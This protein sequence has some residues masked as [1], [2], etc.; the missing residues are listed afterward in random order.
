MNPIR[1][2]LTDD[3]TVVR[4]G[5][6]LLIESS[7]YDV[8]AFKSAEDFLDSNFREN[9]CCLVLDICLPGMSGFQLQQHLVKSQT[10]IPV[11]FITGHDRY[12]MGERYDMDTIYY[13]DGKTWHGASDY[14]EY[15]C[16]FHWV[17]LHDYIG[18]GFDLE[19]DLA[20]MIQ[21]FQQGKRLSL[22]IRNEK[23]NPLYTT[24]FMCALFEEESQKLFNVRQAIL[25]HM[26]Q[27]GNPSPF[28]R[29]Q[30]TRLA[31]LCL[32][33]LIDKCEKDDRESSFI[34]MQ[35]GQIHFHDM[36]DFDRMIDAEFQRPKQQWWLEL[37]GIST[38]LAKSGPQAG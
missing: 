2:F 15:P 9:P 18:V 4:A 24:N 36:R 33:H 23:A 16:V 28:D 30:A 21:E 1:V 29:I 37:K 38:L 31:S 20:H 11:I 17:L 13:V 32:D 8:V 19:A 7:G 3:H 6:K 35:N 34:G 26:Q 14:Y 25:G 10:C 27:G 5:L 12:R 22:M